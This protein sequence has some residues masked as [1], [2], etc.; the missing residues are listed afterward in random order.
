MVS[1]AI[2]INDESPNIL[3]EQKNT[4]VKTIVLN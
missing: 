4:K 3:K 1:V 2:I